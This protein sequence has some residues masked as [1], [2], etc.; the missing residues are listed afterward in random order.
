MSSSERVIFILCDKLTTVYD[1]VSSKY[2]QY[3]QDQ[4][5]IKLR[6]LLFAYDDCQQITTLFVE[7]LTRLACAANKSYT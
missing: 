5:Q 4:K 3:L 1:A 7:T 2:L 6:P